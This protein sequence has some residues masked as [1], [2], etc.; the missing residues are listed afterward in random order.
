MKKRVITGLILAI[1]LLTAVSVSFAAQAERIEEFTAEPGETGI[2][3]TLPAGYAEKGYFKLF[4]KDPASGEVQSTVFRADT[5]EYRIEA[6]A[7][8]EYSFQKR[9]T[10]RTNKFGRTVGDDGSTRNRA[11]LSPDD[12]S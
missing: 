4:W 8:K 2:T 1:I 9:K 12:G 11:P 6:E 7:G 5:A 10:A 3:V